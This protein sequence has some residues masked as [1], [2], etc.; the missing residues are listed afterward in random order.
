MATGERQ[1]LQPMDENSVELSGRW[2]KT[3]QDGGAK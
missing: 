3:L 2:T 1:L